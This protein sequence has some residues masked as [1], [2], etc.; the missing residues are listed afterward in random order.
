[1]FCKNCGASVVGR[2]CSCCGRRVR[3]EIE[4]FRLAQQRKRR[5]FLND[6]RTS[7][8]SAWWGHL[9]EACWE[10]SSMKYRKD[11]TFD[12]ASYMEAYENLEEI[13]FHA[14]GLFCELR[15]F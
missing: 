1:M 5:E 14:W 10:A 2:F 6:C 8:D 13:R 12:G 7:A 15:D 11:P 9:A 4:D 3:S